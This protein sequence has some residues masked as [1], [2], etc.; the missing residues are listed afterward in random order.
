M[1]KIY[2][3][4]ILLW[5]AIPIQAQETIQHDPTNTW[6]T[7]FNR[8]KINKKWSFSNE[9]HER[10]GGFLSKQSTFLERPSIDYHLKDNVEISLGYSF[11]SNRIPLSDTNLKINTY[12]NNIWEQILLKHKIST[13]D[14]LHRFRQEHRWFDVLAKGSNENFNKD[15]VNFANRFRYRLTMVLPLK[16]FGNKKVVFLQAFDEIWLPQTDN[17]MPK[18]FSRNWFYLGVGYK[19]NSNTNLQ[20]GYMSEWNVIATDTY[21]SKPIIQTTFVKSFTL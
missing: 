17:L 11:L 9:L 15:G 3:I 19:F 13:V 16:T 1:K 4:L 5:I 8:V 20:L 6:F 18:S 10:L 7:L 14:I 12:E 21:K 2:S